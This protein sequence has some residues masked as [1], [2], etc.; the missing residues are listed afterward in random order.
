MFHKSTDEL[1][2][3][4]Y[5]LNSKYTDNS[6]QLL[7]PQFLLHMVLNVDLSKHIMNRTLTWLRCAF[8]SS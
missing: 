6:Y 5:K 2:P 1:K 8:F 7:T 4:V 3:Q